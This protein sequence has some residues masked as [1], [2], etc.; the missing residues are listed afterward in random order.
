MPFRRRL[1]A[2]GTEV[3]YDSGDYPLL[4]DKALA[5]IGWEGLQAELRQRRSAGELVG[6]GIGLFVEKGG[7]GPLDG[8]RVSI[9][10]T[11]AVELV[12][13]GSSVGQG[14]ATAMA[15]ICADTLGVDYRRGRVVLGQTDRIQYGI[16]AHASRASVMTGSAT[17]EAALR[18]RAKALDVAASLLHAAPDGLA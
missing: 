7:L 5:R 2:L 15:Q 9:D 4:L 6:A 11:G 17:H 13:G 1:S 18:V 10:A 14:I 3:I 8:A 12:T 16:G